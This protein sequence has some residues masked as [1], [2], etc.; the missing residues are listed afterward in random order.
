MRRQPKRR[1]LL[2][3]GGARNSAT[4]T[5]LLL[6]AD[7]CRAIIDAAAQAEAVGRPFNRFITI[8]W[9]N[10][11]FPAQRCVRAT[12]HFIRLV[13]D[14]ARRHGYR[15]VWAWT[16]ESSHKRGAHVHVLLHVPNR[17]VSQFRRMPLAWVKRVLGRYESGVLNTQRI[18]GSSTGGPMS[19]TYRENL[20]RKIRYMLKASSEATASQFGLG[21]CNEGCLVFG[22]RAGVWQ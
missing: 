9:Q 6:T 18:R 4:R 16:Q 21:R 19:A 3:R 22:K 5:S 20:D 15:L 12:G 14:W 10:G 11:G 17:L 2:Q 7:Q 8:A 1:R 13:R